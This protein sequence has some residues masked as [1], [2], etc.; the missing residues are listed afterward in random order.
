[1]VEHF[2]CL[3]FVFDRRSRGRK[4]STISR[5]RDSQS[6]KHQKELKACMFF[7]GSSITL[8]VTTVF[9]S[10]EMNRDLQVGEVYFPL[11]HPHRNA[12]PGLGRPRQEDAWGSLDSQFILVGELQTSV[13][14]ESH[15]APEDDSRGSLLISH[16]HTRTLIH[17]CESAPTYTT[18]YTFTERK[19]CHDQGLSQ[20][21]L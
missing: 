17:T 6:R 9:R 4:V 18:Q 14:K 21:F 20:V 5:N 12:R 19:I 11:Q 10:I 7:F 15:G 13:S 2:P 8:K 16:A 3:P 1:M